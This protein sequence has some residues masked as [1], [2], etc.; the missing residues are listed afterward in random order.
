M[1]NQKVRSRL[2]SDRKKES[3][4]AY[5]MLL[6]DVLGLLIFVFF[7]IIYALYISFHDWNGL[8]EM[9]FSGLSN[10]QTLL[11]DKA[12][13]NSLIVSLQYMLLYVPIVFVFS[14]LLA[15]YLVSLKNRRIRTVYRTMYFLPYAISTVVAGLIWSFMYNPKRGI[16]N[17]VLNYFGIESQRWTASRDQALVSV[18]VVATWLVIGYNTV[19]LLNAIQDIPVE[20]YEASTIDGANSVQRFFRITVPLVKDTSVFVIITAMIAALQSFDL[21]QIMTKGGPANATTTVVLY[22]YRQAFEVNK[23]GY[24]SALS[25]ILFI[26]IMVLSIITFAITSRKDD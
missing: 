11:K 15:N 25:F 8:S 23:M 5:L 4:T 24:A 16:L 3:I 19:L 17:G 21:I 1:N 13:T 2:S 14:L 18:V 6:P 26:I 7:P 10:Y 12:F 9:V 22:I 20:Y